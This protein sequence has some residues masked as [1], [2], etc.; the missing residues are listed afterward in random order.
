MNNYKIKDKSTI[1]GAKSCSYMY[2]TFEKIQY[3]FFFI[4]RGFEGRKDFLV[5]Y[6]N[7]FDQFA[8]ECMV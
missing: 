2:K 5:Y 4:K 7:N 6:D 3:M 1:I 8:N